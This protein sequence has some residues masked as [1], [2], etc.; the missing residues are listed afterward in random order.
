MLSIIV[1]AYR[2][3]KTIKV[4][5]DSIQKQI[6][7]EDEVLVICPD[8]ET[9][10]SVEELKNQY[11]NIILFKDERKGKPAAL[12]IGLRHAKGEI[13]VLTDGDVF[14]ESNA[15]PMLVKNLYLDKNIGAVCGHPIS[16]NSKNTI[17]G[18]W[19]HALTN[20]LNNNRKLLSKQNRYIQCSGYLYAIRAGI[21]DSI[22]ENSLADD[23]VISYKVHEAGYRIAYEEEALVKVKYPLNYYDW[24]KQKTRSTAGHTQ[25]E[26][27]KPEKNNRSFFR[28]NRTRRFKCNF[29]CNKP[30]RIF[31]VFFITLGETTCLG[32]NFL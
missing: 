24:L 28:R 26:I 4:A 20:I 27:Y 5:I 29:I 32:I 2:E 13:I 30:K 10:K 25:A 18:Y 6:S 22:P 21:V 14:L 1:T 23:A 9:V 17:L 3:P 16:L 19:S 31:L 8:P 11:K 15:I 12:N 7:H